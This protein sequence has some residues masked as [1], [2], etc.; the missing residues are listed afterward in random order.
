MSDKLQS[1]LDRV[2]AATTELRAATEAL[3]ALLPPSYAI[4]TFLADDFAAIAEK[5]IRTTAEVY[6][7]TVEGILGA[8]RQQPLATARHVAMAIISDL[9]G[10]PGQVI[11][12]RFGKTDHNAVR[13]AVQSIRT[14]RQNE[15]TTRAAYAAIMAR[16]ATGA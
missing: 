12:A 2:A 3:I 7:V 6:Q 15:R 4:G 1:A 9:T 16:L 10:A 14:R 11:A 8:S 13:W 5:V